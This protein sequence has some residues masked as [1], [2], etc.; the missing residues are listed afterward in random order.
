MN[1]PADFE[2]YIPVDKVV[3]RRTL[4]ILKKP[5]T[6]ETLQRLKLLM[7][8][9]MGSKSCLGLSKCHSIDKPGEGSEDECKETVEFRYLEGTLDPELILRWR[10]EGD[11]YFWYNRIETTPNL[12]LDPQQLARRPVDN[13]EILLPLDEEYIDALREE[14]CT[15]E[16]RLPCMIQK[17]ATLN[18]SEAS[19]NPDDLARI[20][21]EK[22]NI[23]NA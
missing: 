17:A 20:V 23:F 8:P 9:S 10:K 1:V 7:T 5:W 22:V 18:E 11:F 14:L 19:T 2:R 4:G 16:M 15:R 12:P 3:N 21:S 13:N 6:A